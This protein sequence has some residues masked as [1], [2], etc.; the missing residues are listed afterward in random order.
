MRYRID[1]RII[2]DSEYK[3]VSF[4][5]KDGETFT[6]GR[7][8]SHLR[9]HHPSV[10]RHHCQ[11]T[12]QGGEVLIMDTA[13]TNGVFINSQKITRTVLKARDSVNVGRFQIEIMDLVPDDRK[14]FK[15]SGTLDRNSNEPVVI[16]SDLSHDDTSTEYP[17]QSQTIFLSELGILKRVSFFI[18]SQWMKY[19]S[20]S[21]MAFS[22]VIVLIGL[23]ITTWTVLRNVSMKSHTPKLSHGP[24]RV[25]KKAEIAQA[26]QIGP[27][28]KGDKFSYRIKGRALGVGITGRL[29]L[30]VTQWHEE[31]K[32]IQVQ[33]IS[34]ING[35]RQ[36]GLVQNSPKI[37][38]SDLRSFHLDQ[39]FDIATLVKRLLDISTVINQTPE[40]LAFELAQADLARESR[41]GPMEPTRIASFEGYQIGQ[42]TS[43]RRPSSDQPHFGGVFSVSKSVGLPL[44]FR[45][46]TV[47]GNVIEVKLRK[48]SSLHSK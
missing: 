1:I 36:S 15:A 44:G 5:L 4:V 47:Y 34:E 22:A 8:A 2:K 43:G 16:E 3:E 10:S 13:S 45:A 42:S 33:Y 40:R 30:I 38:I 7:E 17:D 18:R 41:L 24:D 21:K 25:I 28:T 39:T 31:K 27:I 35:T 20:E 9:L 6:I 26:F 23:S 48:A 32:E 29:N 19:R 12:I 14:H 46:E 37:Q 11:I